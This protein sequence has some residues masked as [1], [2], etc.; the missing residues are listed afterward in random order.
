MGIV[1]LLTREGEVTIAKRI[2]RG[3]MKTQKSISRSPIAVER[4]LKIGEDLAVGKASIRETVAF[5]EQAEISLEEDKAEEYLRWTLEG[6]GNIR[7]NYEAALKTWIA[8]RKEQAAS[9]ATGKRSRKLI[10]LTRQTARAR[11]EIAQEIKNLNLT[12]HSMQ[13]LIASIRK[14][15][16][17]I[18]KSERLIK[19][20]E[21]RLSKKPGAA[22]KRDLNAKIAEAKEALAFRPSR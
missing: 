6:I 17:E 8:L 3:Q 18:R 16:E 22:E 10:R 11:L 14:V 13:V 7:Q 12:E 2:E 15:V 5:S 21:E 19:K 4:L 9:A 20:S 1:P